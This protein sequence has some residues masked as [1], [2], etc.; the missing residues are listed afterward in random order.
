M[1]TT[2]RR[3]RV[4]A[5]AR[6]AAVT[7]GDAEQAAG[8]VQA[9]TGHVALGNDIAQRDTGTGSAAAGDVHVT[10]DQALHP[11]E[12]TFLWPAV[13]GGHPA[14]PWLARRQNLSRR[15]LLHRQQSL[16]IGAHIAGSSAIDRYVRVLLKPQPCAFAASLS[17]F[18]R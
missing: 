13:H 9:R 17:A 3:R 8:V 6:A 4:A 12:R 16:L 2:S 15:F 11:V 7:A 5:T 14:G 18:F 10:V 1:E